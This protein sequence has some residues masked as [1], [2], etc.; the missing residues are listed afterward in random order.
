LLVSGVEAEDGGDRLARL[1]QSIALELIGEQVLEAVEFL[2]AGVCQ[3][4]GGL[5]AIAAPPG[6]PHGQDFTAVE[7]PLFEIANALR[8]DLDVLFR[9]LVLL[10]QLV[11][12]A[13]MQLAGNVADE[14]LIPHDAEAVEVVARVGVVAAALLRGH[15]ERS[16]AAAE[17][18]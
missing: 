11:L 12:P 10:D 14:E 17:E 9:H 3:S 2:G 15:I 6:W 8:D 16:A 7:R 1:G 4:A 13:R 5:A 18:S